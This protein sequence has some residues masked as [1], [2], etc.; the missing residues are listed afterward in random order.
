MGKSLS[1]T[2]IAEG[3]ETSEQAD[4]LRS[5]ACDEFQGFYFADACRG[6]RSFAGST[7]PG[8]LPPPA[9]DPVKTAS[10]AA[11]VEKT[12]VLL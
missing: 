3:V 8:S 9:N 12:C 2:V 11:A 1:L 6:A 4:F 10:V 5:H 7:R